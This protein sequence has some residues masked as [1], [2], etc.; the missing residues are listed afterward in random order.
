[1]AALDLLTG[2]HATY[3]DGNDQGQNLART[4]SELLMYQPPHFREERLDVQHGLIRAHPFGALVSAGCGWPGGEPFPIHHRCG[5]LA[6]RDVARHVAR[7]NDQWEALDGSQDALVI[8]QGA[9]A[10]VSPSW[11]PTKAE[12]GKVVPTWNYAIVHAHGRPRI[13]EDGAWLLRHV[14]ELTV[15]HEAASPCPGASRTRRPSSWPGC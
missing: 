9:Y 5:C 6:A 3:A 13:V 2:P 10:Y 15:Q 7:A 1:M 8:F 14:S 4:L 11:Y 12:T